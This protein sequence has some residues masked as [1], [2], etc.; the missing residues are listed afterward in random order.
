MAIYFNA[1]FFG[2][3]PEHNDWLSYIEAVGTA[4][5][6]LGISAVLFR[7]IQL[8]IQQDLKTGFVWI[9]KIITD[10]FHDIYIYHKA[11]QHLLQWERFERDPVMDMGDLEPVPNH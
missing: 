9:T 4:W 6:Y 10:P 1:G 7:G 2:I 5:L 8:F 11:P 3:L